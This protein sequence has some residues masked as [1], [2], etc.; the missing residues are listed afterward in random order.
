M[1]ILDYSL[2]ALF[3]VFFLVGLIRGLKH[4]A[5]RFEGDIFAFLFAFFFAGFLVGVLYLNFPNFVTFYT[6]FTKTM[7]VDTF[8]FLG[9]WI[10]ALVLILVLFLPLFFLFRF[11]YR[12]LA[13]KRVYTAFLSLFTYLLA[14]YVIGLVFVSY[15]HLS[16]GS[17][18]D[19]YQQSLLAPSLYPS[20]SI[21]N[22]FALLGGYFHG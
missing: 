17:L 22:Y 3:A 19:W 2:L 15:A 18:N 9:P 14:A 20:D 13:N 12:H 5:S 7:T 4:R 1:S 11:F 6:D 10:I 8:P 21:L 16:S